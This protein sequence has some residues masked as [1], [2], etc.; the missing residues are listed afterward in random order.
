MVSVVSFVGVDVDRLERQGAL[1]RIH[2]G[3]VGLVARRRGRISVGAARRNP[4]STPTRLQRPG[5][6]AA[7]LSRRMP[8]SCPLSVSPVE[9]VATRAMPWLSMTMS[10]GR[11]VIGGQLGHIARVPGCRRTG[12]DCLTGRRQSARCRQHRSWRR[13]RTSCCRCR[14]GTGVV[15]QWSQALCH[16]RIDCPQRPPRKITS[17]TWAKRVKPC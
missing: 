13:G 8:N 10:R 9:L 12:I 15:G 2:H 11:G 7:Q 17:C 1:L 5:P 4:A 6:P 16:R 14:P 3:D